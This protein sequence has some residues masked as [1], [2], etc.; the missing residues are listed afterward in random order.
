MAVDLFGFS[1]D[2]PASTIPEPVSAALVGLALL[3]A[4]AP[5]ATRADLLRR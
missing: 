3:G 1:F 5:A 2:V 4:A